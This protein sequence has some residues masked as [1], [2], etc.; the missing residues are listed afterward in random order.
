MR[1][2]DGGNETMMNTAKASSFMHTIGLTLTIFYAEFPAIIAGA[3]QQIIIH[4]AYFHPIR[5]SRIKQ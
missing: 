3:I 5:H 2:W 1:F 4:L